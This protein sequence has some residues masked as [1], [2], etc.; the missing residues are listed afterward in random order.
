[1]EKYEKYNV[2]IEKKKKKDVLYLELWI[3]VQVLLF[4]ECVLFQAYLG[5]SNTFSIL[6][7][8]KIQT[9]LGFCNLWL[10]TLYSLQ[11]GI[12]MHIQDEMSQQIGTKA[13]LCYRISCWELV[14]GS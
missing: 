10:Y 3:I 7:E 14:L 6:R 9:S 1:M 4:V 2:L 8:E 11:D 13:A 12:Q 5:K